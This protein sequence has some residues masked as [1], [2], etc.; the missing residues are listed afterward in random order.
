MPKLINRYKKVNKIETMF[1]NETPKRD[2]ASVLVFFSYSQTSA[3]CF[4]TVA[5][6]STKSANK[7]PSFN[8]IN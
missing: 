4:V 2:L 1:S 3:T 5:H 8:H 6:F 7:N